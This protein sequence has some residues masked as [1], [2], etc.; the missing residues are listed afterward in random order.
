MEEKKVSFFEYEA[1]MA[2][3]ERVTH[4]LWIYSLVLL[5]FLVGTN[6]FWIFQFFGF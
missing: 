3:L 4:R 1:T 6:L 2:R 5:G